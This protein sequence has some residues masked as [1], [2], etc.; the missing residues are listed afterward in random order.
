MAPVL[1]SP[2]QTFMGVPHETEPGVAKA[3]ILGLPFDC[4]NH[5]TRV[6]ARAGPASIREQSQLVSAFDGPS[7]VNPLDDLGVVDLG[8]ALT[9]PGEL[10]RS[11]EAM[12]AAMDAALVNHALPI[13]FGGDGSIALPQM[14]S[15]NR[16]YPGLVVLHLDAHTDAYPLEGY[17]NATPF[18][19]AFDEG[20]IDAGHSFHVGTR[21]AHGIPGIYNYGRQLG[22]RIIPMDELVD[23]G[24][25][26]V[27]IDI[28]KTIEDRPV[29]LCFDMDFFDPA[30]AP[31][32]CTP[33]WGGASAREGIQALKSC[34]GL[35]IVGMDINT[36]SPPHD[37]N[38]MSAMLAATL[39]Y[40][41][42]LM[43]AS[44]AIA[45]PRTV[46]T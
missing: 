5:P 38:G 46:F 15:L 11:Y 10:E 29:Y 14:R 18:A 7:S 8:D 31:G 25:D 24:I 12:E 17:S 28:K 36:I 27:F 4:G 19:R 42:L 21:R 32:V 30:V 1:F 3:V 43:M 16:L 45:C 22:Y 2:P 9:Y 23:R 34:A 40:E 13:T 41:F 33:A 44:G 20:V 35:N 39:A 26:D 37:C 6:G